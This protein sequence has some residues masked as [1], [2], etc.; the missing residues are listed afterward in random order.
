MKTFIS[1]ILFLVA[2]GFN[3]QAQCGPTVL[4]PTPEAVL[5]CEGSDTLVTFAATGTCAGTYQYQ[6]QI[7]TTVVQAW[8]SANSYLAAPIVST[9]Y[10]VK[11]RCSTCPAQ[12]VTAE[13]IIEVSEEPTLSGNTFI[14]SG[15]TT[16]LLATTDTTA[17]TWWDSATAGNQL[18]TTN[19]YTTPPLTT[20]KTY[21]AQ[22]SAST[23]N[24]TTG[25]VLITECGTD[26][27]NGG[28]G[29][30][31]YIEISNLY[32]TAINTTGW[33]VAVSDS[34]T[35]INSVNSVLWYLPSS[36]SPCSVVTKTD[37][38]GSANYWGSNIFWNPN[39]NSWAIIIDNLGNVVDFIAWGWT[40]AQIA[41]LNTTINGFNITIGAQW[42][43][44]GCPSNCGVINGQ[45]GSYSRTGNADNNVAADFICQV[46]STNLVNAGLSCG[47][48]ASA[49]CRYPIEIIVDTPPTASNPATQHYQCP[50]DVP[51]PNVNV[52]IDEA[53]DYTSIPIVTLVSSVSD[54]LTCPETITRTYKVADS[55]TNFVLVTQ[56]II[57][58]DT[59]PPVFAATPVNITVQCS[60][61]IPAMTNLNWT[62]NCTG[63]GSVVGTDVSDGLSCPETIIRTWT[64]A[65]NCGNSI[66]TS[67]I[68]KVHDTTN[69]VADA[70]VDVQTI[71]LP[72]ADINELT[73]VSDNCSTPIVTHVSDVSDGG[74]CPEI[75]IRKYSVK[76]ACDNEIFITQKFIIGDPVPNAAFLTS[77]TE[78]SNMETHVDFTNIT[79]GAASYVWNF[80]DNSPEETTF[81]AN[82]DFPDTEG[83]GYIV[84]LIAFSPFGCS[85]TA[86]VVIQVIEETIYYVPNAF[87]PN[88]DELN[89]QFK[90]VI[91]SG[92]DVNN[93][94]FYIYNRWGQLIFESH[95]VDFGWDGTYNG[96]LV[97]DDHF[98]W[99]IKFKSIYS[100]KKKEVFGGVSITR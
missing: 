67:Q 46:T 40:G 14:C 34:Y 76:D 26:G 58:K 44:N 88:G 72:P 73:G 68:I 13:F 59:I 56:T 51:A 29:S 10:T 95:D 61:D 37:I 1:L 12:I 9:L 2:F 32:S 47:W 16:S 50:A 53:D 66:T 79:T 91:Y 23:S 82:H 87:T 54:G 97:K 94:E 99:K 57:V 70:M 36:F 35:N 25:S 74:Y 19:T 75:V 6:V 89:Q 24:S 55:C 31:D 81:H 80:G 15:E 22:A 17:V 90:P 71:E 52:V 41:G 8:G 62:D 92:I 3:S 98:T 27:M 45:M 4:T 42:S 43:G 60:A 77:S 30:E 64:Y 93:Y 65:D 100:D 96:K 21:W 18:S 83:A 39:S 63:S 85:D 48:S 78:L 38:V 49:T 20:N 86:K 69:P 5:L 11:V 33:V 84:K 28:T 7:G